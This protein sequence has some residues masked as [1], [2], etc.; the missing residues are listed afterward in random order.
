VPAV[1]WTPPDAGFVAWLDCRASGLGDDPAE[2]ILGAGRLAV[3][4]GLDFG[5]A[6]AGHVRLAFGTTAAA[7]EESVVRLGAALA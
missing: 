4:S 1:R 2:A 3:G 7:V 6:G 5:A